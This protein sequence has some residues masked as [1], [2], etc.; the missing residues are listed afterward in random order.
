MKKNNL[1]QKGSI[2][3]FALLMIAAVLVTFVAASSVL[4]QQPGQGLP[5]YGSDRTS[6]PAASE[7]A[8]PASLPAATTSGGPSPPIKLATPAVAKKLGT[9]KPK[10]STKPGYT[11][12]LEDRAGDYQTHVDMA[13][14]WLKNGQNGPK[15]SGAPS[16]S[17]SVAPSGSPAAGPSSTPAGPARTIGH[18]EVDAERA[19]Y[20]QSGEL[21]PGSLADLISKAVATSLGELKKSVEALGKRMDKIEKT[22]PPVGG[23]SPAPS[24]SAPGADGS[25]GL[26]SSASP[27]GSE[28]EGSG[29][30]PSPATSGSPA[31]AALPPIVL[32]WPPWPWLTPPSPTPAGSPAASSSP[33][34]APSGTASVAPPPPPPAETK[35]PPAANGGGGDDQRQW[36]DKDQP[37]TAGSLTSPAPSTGTT[38][39]KAVGVIFLMILLV[40]GLGL[41]IKIWDKKIIERG[42]NPA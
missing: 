18:H 8:S 28:G 3:V 41:G 24:A 25:P 30:P 19:R 4:A 35:S 20:P 40:V 42:G 38:A 21:A 29:T 12:T 5:A 32:Q 15:P 13:R 37:A 22:A 31:P 14:V 26:A 6:S 2:M 11:P 27:S 7:S 16:A 23:T 10:P 1:R 9:P 36:G 34:T 39:G 33:P 17:P